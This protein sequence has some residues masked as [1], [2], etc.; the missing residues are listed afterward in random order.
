MGG[1]RCEGSKS[2]EKMVRKH[3]EINAWAKKLL[4]KAHASYENQSNESQRHIKFSTSDLVW[5]N[6]WNF[7]KMLKALVN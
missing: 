4:E 7:L 6:I 1:N 5:L 3:E 2:V